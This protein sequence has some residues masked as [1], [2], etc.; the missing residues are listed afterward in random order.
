MSEFVWTPLWD[1]E[2]V[3]AKSAA[4]ERNKIRAELRRELYERDRQ[5]PQEPLPLLLP[6]QETSP[7]HDRTSE[8]QERAA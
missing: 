8:L 1:A 2:S 4:I 7:Q 6:G 3:L 5:Q